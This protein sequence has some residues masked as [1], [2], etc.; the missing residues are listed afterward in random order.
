[1]RSSY[2]PLVG[3]RQ[4]RLVNLTK[5]MFEAR[6]AVS[7]H[8]PRFALNQRVFGESRGARG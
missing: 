1:M 5:T 6:L 2:R 8:Q 3:D 7:R 4:A